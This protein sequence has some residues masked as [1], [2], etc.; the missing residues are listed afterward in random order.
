MCIFYPKLDL[1]RLAFHPEWKERA[2]YGVNDP[3][4]SFPVIFCAVFMI[5]L[6]NRSQDHENKPIRPTIMSTTTALVET[7]PSK[8]SN[9]SRPM[10]ANR[11]QIALDHER[12]QRAMGIVL[13]PSC[14]Y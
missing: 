9:P 6:G 3:I 5:V 4:H 11:E 14:E 2:Q 1:K 13:L 12:R 10:F 8:E 7:K